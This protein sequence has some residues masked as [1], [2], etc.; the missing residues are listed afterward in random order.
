MKY[1]YLLNHTIL[2]FTQTRKF[3]H[4]LSLHDLYMIFEGYNLNVNKVEGLKFQI[5]VEVE[6]KN[7]QIGEEK[8]TFWATNWGGGV[9]GE[10]IFFK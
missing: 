1:F 2:L 5:I 8:K 10:I 9:A 3:S 6:E 4:W 7:Q